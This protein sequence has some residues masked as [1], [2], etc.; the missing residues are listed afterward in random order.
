MHATTK[1]NLAAS[2]AVT[3]AVDLAK[4]VFELALAD[5]GGRILERKR[6]INTPQALPFF[7]L[8]G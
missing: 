2:P 7:E 1:S 4:D 6:L 8:P 3:L 5:A